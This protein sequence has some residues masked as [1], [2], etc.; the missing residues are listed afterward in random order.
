MPRHA[1]PHTSVR[2]NL[3]L[4][5]S[6]RERLEHL[7]RCTEADSLSE[8]VRRAI[9]VYALIVE[10]GA[11]VTIDGRDMLLPEAKRP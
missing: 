5:Q 2:L 11:T 1:K 4:A 10:H 3:E 7:Q 9:T 6:V 8:V